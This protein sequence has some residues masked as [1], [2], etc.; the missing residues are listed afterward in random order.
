MSCS[1]YGSGVLASSSEMQ[2]GVTTY[3]L[4]KA[5]AP[6][7]SG[8]T[9]VMLSRHTPASHHDTA[10]TTTAKGGTTPLANTGLRIIQT[11][12]ATPTKC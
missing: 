7:D 2:D 8:P 12:S 5:T 6:N 9:R 10:V 3:H 4:L 1:Q 11:N